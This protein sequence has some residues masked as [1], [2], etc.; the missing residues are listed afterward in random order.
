MENRIR[1]LLIFFSLLFFSCST[2]K[3]ENRKTGLYYGDE[4]IYDNEGNFIHYYF[5]SEKYLILKGDIGFK[6]FV[7]DKRLKII[8]YDFNSSGDIFLVNDI[9]I[10]VD[11]FYISSWYY[12]DLRSQ[13]FNKI[14]YYVTK[15][16]LKDGENFAEGIKYDENRN[17]IEF[18][19][20]LITHEKWQH[21]DEVEIQPINFSF[22]GNLEDYNQKLM[23]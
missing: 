18:S 15:I 19:E 14:N 1:M 20:N 23:E 3:L 17:I 5:E 16:Y 6:Y 9:L 10:Y 4:R 2:I 11:E 8:T 12:C 21:T 22:I 13:T 7:Y